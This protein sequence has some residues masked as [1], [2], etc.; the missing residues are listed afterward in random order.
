MVVY[1]VAVGLLLLVFI[2]SYYG[3]RV[4]QVAAA[5]AF[6]GH[7]FVSVILVPTV[8]YNWDIGQFHQV[9]LGI[10]AGEL[11]SASSTVTSFGT[12]QGLFYILFPSQ[13][14][15]MGVFNGLF[16]VLVVIPVMFLCD[17]LYPNLN[18]PQHGVMTIVLF[19]PLPF[20]LLSVPMRDALSVLM[21][22]SI[23][24][25]AV[26]ILSTR[27]VFLV[28][29]LI[30]LWG[31]LFLFRPELALVFLVGIMAAI[32]V[33]IM[34]AVDL[35]ISLPAMTAGLGV[36][37]VLG[38]SLFAEF[39]YSLERANAE[40]AYRASGGAVYLDGMQYSSWFEFILVAPTR[41]LYFQFAPFPLHVEQVFHLL[42]FTMT[43]VVILLFVSA[44]RSLYGV[45]YNETVAVLL[46]VVYLAGISGYGLINSNFGTNVRHRIVFDFLLVVMAAPV[47]K[48]WELR[49]REWLGIVPSDGSEHDEQQREAEKLDRHVYAGRQHANET[50]E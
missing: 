39:I 30:P 1:P 8:P 26:Q 22:F 15:T 28:L 43:P 46:V 17:R 3:D 38:V 49:V 40:L 24:A 25:L 36:L 20:F 48:R 2:S 4:Y 13:P 42:T 29:P 35:D 11:V 9:A 45:E 41:A 37:G 31:M 44:A 10:E 19:L 34:R 16:A 6:A 23:L 14:E 33:E 5:I 18:G 32:G 50:E 21:F 7:A 27:N 12:V 47:V